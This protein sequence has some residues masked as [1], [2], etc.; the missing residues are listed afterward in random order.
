M[1]SCSATKK[2]RGFLNLSLI[3]KTIS[4]LRIFFLN[5]PQSDNVAQCIGYYC[6]WGVISRVVLYRHN[7]TQH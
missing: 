1:L 3:L 2:T 5:V 7:T 4:C 6:G